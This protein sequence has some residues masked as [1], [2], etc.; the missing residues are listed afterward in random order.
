M[1]E[2]VGHQAACLGEALCEK[3]KQGIKKGCVWR[4]VLTSSLNDKYP[5]LSKL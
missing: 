5:I 2:R 4:P 3:S 1:V